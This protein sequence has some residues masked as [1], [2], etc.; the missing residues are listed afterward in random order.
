MNLSQLKKNI[1]WRVQLEPPAVHLDP[2]GRELPDRNEDWIIQSVSDTQV[3][4]TE[5]KIL[6]L[7]TILGKDYVQSF[8]RV[9]RR[10]VRVMDL[11][12]VHSYSV[13]HCSRYAWME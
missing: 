13:D 5:A 7:G 11:G 6:G 8:D 4:I 3:C 2:R 10:G 9:P 1:G 12:K